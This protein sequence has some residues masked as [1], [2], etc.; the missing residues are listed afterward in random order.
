MNT[1]VENDPS[2]E[3]NS[4]PSSFQPTTSARPIHEN[5]SARV[6]IDGLSVLC[7]R[8]DPADPQKGAV[9][10][11]FLAKEHEPVE[12]VVFDKSGEETFRYPKKGDPTQNI[13]VEIR[14][15]GSEER[16]VF[17]VD[18]LSSDPK[19]CHWMPDLNQWHAPSVRIKPTSALHLSAKLILNDATF[20][21]EL[22]AIN[23]A[24][25]FH[26]DSETV[27]KRPTLGRILGADLSDFPVKISVFAKDEASGSVTEIA[28]HTIPD[29]EGQH[30]IGFRYKSD[31]NHDAMHL[32]YDYLI[33][34]HDCSRYS[35]AYEK[36]EPD[37]RLCGWIGDSSDRKLYINPPPA[38]I[39]KQYW[40]PF[41][42]IEDA[43]TAGYSLTFP[44]QEK[45]TEFACQVFGG[46]DGPLP[47]LP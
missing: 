25:R 43:Q 45:A 8:G 11:A 1:K 12:V 9:E 34:T 26:I 16:G 13:R 4:A 27:N 46:G 18:D 35:L 39:P 37:W 3:P 32:L 30:Y 41:N 21:T 15:E 20:Y 2:D 28:S 5:A 23:D 6:F 44:F 40:V 10:I 31:C 7:V 29:K 19:S 33:W 14:K 42:T 38:T 17:Y 22:R 47:E 36:T 24:V